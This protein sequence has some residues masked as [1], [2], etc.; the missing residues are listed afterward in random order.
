M[1]K[2][3]KSSP[4][5]NIAVYV[6]S[7]FLSLTLVFITSLLVVGGTL[8]NDK[9]LLSKVSGT[10][11]FSELNNEI[12]TRCNTVAVK[13]GVDYKAVES[14][15][16]SGR[17]DSDFTVYFNSVSGKNPKGGR[18][19][20][21][22]KAL[23]DELYSA[24][25]AYDSDITEEEKANAKV[26]AER[27]AKEYKDSIVVESFENYLSFAESFKTVSRYILLILVALAVYLAFVIISLNGKKQ[28]HRLFRRFAIVAGSSGLTVLVFALLTKFSGILEQ[29]TFASTQR[30]YNLFMNFFDDFLMLIIAVGVCWTVICIILLVLWYLSVTGR[31]KK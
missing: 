7:F 11:Y 22:E 23:A 26:I 25:T 5:K 4:G 8:F 1:K 14:V 17:I 16:T 3:K 10:T 30:E 20:I 6:V 28:K 21:D 2:N 31:L 18:D 13:S 24:I 15:L 19:T 9:D 27:M 29:I 12:I